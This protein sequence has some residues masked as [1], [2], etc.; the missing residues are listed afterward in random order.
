[1]SKRDI[2]ELENKQ[3]GKKL[4]I[5]EKDLESYNKELYKNV[6]NNNFKFC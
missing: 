1:M 6:N 4:I 2:M 5:V 3:I